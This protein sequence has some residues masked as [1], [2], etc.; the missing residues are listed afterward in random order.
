V[1]IGGD[2]KLSQV[3]PGMRQMSDMK[4]PQ[5]SKNGRTSCPPRI[6]TIRSVVNPDKLGHLG[7]CRTLPD[8]LALPRAECSPPSRLMEN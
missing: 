3:R 1:T 4:K 2:T 8:W 5:S 6:Q 7:P